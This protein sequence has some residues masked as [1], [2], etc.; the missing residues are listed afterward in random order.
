LLLLELLHL[1]SSRERRGVLSRSHTGFGAVDDIAA[2][3]TQQATV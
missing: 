1:C 2:D 3:A